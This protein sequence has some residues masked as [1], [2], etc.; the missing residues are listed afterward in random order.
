[1]G[2]GGSN[3]G[4]LYVRQTSPPLCNGSGLKGLSGT[5]YAL[6][7]KAPYL[8]SLLIPLHQASGQQKQ[9]EVAGGAEFQR[10]MVLCA[11]VL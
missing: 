6:Q 1:M 8:F 5:E 11:L 10:S 2:G 3:P 4:L 7:L 9:E